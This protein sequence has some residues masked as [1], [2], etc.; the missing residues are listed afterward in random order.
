MRGSKRAGFVCSETSNF[1]PRESNPFD[2]LVDHAHQLNRVRR[3]CSPGESA[4]QHRERAFDRSKRIQDFDCETFRSFAARAFWRRRDGP[5]LLQFSSVLQI[6]AHETA[7][8]HTPCIG[9]RTSFLLPF[10]KCRVNGQW[11]AHLRASPYCGASKPH[12]TN[13]TSDNVRGSGTFP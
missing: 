1:E 8:P 2:E 11:I 13:C 6:V 9:C 12:E 5:M 10:E 3:S 7:P 4:Q